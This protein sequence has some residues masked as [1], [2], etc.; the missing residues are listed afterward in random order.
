MRY[1]LL[2]LFFVSCLPFVLVIALLWCHFVCVHHF[3]V[4]FAGGLCVCVFLV[5]QRKVNVTFELQSLFIILSI[6]F[7]HLQAMLSPKIFIPITGGLLLD[8]FQEIGAREHIGMLFT[9]ERINV[10]HL[11][12]FVSATRD[13]HVIVLNF[14]LFFRL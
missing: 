2:D 6:F 14:V 12:S 9:L 11:A 10:P 7:V 4:V 3:F 8:H 13:L 1:T 5:G